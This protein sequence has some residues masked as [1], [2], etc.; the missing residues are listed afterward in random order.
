MINKVLL[1]DRVTEMNCYTYSLNMKEKEIRVYYD[2]LPIH[3]M[4]PVK[5]ILNN[6]MITG[7]I[8]G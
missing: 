1:F 4:I 8:Y 6:F 5:E 3:V 7:V 2:G